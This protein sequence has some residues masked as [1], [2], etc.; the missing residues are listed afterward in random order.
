MSIENLVL[1]EEPKH[2]CYRRSLPLLKIACYRH[3]IFLTRPVSELRAHILHNKLPSLALIVRTIKVLALAIF[4]WHLCDYVLLACHEGFCHNIRGKNTVEDFYTLDKNYPYIIES[5]ILLQFKDPIQPYHEG[6][7]FHVHEE[8]DVK[9]IKE[10]TVKSI[11]EYYQKYKKQEI[12][13]KKQ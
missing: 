8:I 7:A 4:R 3:A 12:I 6:L 13:T 11:A 5:A 1:P 10:V 2:I 9:K